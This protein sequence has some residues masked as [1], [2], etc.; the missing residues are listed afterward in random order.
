MKK[1]ILIAALFIICNKIFAQADTSGQY[2]LI[3]RYDLTAP[4]PDAELVK[5]N[6]PKWGTFIGELTRSGK[7]V[8]GL[9]PDNGGKT[10]SGKTTTVEDKPYAGDNKIVSSFFLVKAGSM[11]EATE[12]AKKCPIYELGG[13][14]EVRKV[15]N[16]AN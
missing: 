9:R 8:M 14:V 15:M 13:N 3:V 6:A 1:V 16:M 12:I 11:A 5:A 4:S 2:M 10:I 7:L